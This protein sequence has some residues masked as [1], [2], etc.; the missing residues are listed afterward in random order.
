MTPKSA[1]PSTASRRMFGRGISGKAR[2]EDESMVFTPTPTNALG[3]EAKQKVAFEE[4][5]GT[6]LSGRRPRSAMGHGHKRMA[7]D[8]DV[9]DFVGVGVE[10]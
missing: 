7:S 10:S 8:G 3:L 6:P 1:R 2:S 9:P 5:S 4:M